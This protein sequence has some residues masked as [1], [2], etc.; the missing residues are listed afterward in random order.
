[1]GKKSGPK[2]PPPPDPWETAQAQSQYNK[3][4]AV[5]Q[6]N[7][8]RID[9]ITPQG[10]I[11]YTQIGTN[12]D[13]TPQYQQTMTYSPE[14]QALYNQQNQI[15]QQL[16]QTATQQIDRVNDTM[17]TPF[18]YDG[19]TPQVTSI[20]GAGNVQ[21]FNGQMPGV[22]RGFQAGD[23]QS[24]FDSGGAIQSTFGV[25]GPLTTDAQGG[26][27]Q[28]RIGPNDLTAAGQRVADSV[29][30]QAQSRLD[31]QFQQQQ[32]DLRARLANSGIAEGSEAYNRELGNFNRS[33]TDAYADAN[34]RA[35][36][37]GGA[38]QSRLF[39][40]DQAQGQF[41]N[42]AQ[43]QAY[44]QSM[45]N[46]QLN[47]AAQGQIFGQNQSAAQFGNQAQ[48]Q[49]FAQ[50]QSQGQFYNAAQD[51]DY[52]QQ[53]GQAELF[54]NAGQTWLSQQLAALGF[55]NQAQSQYMNENLANANLQNAG[56][57]QEIQEATYLRNLPLNDIAALLGTGGGV[58]SPEFNPVSQVGVAAP[59]YMGAAY[60]SN[61][62]LQNQYQQAQAN[63]SAGLGSIFG[64]AGTLGAAAI[65]DARFKHNVQR[66]GTLA[67]GLA[68]YVFS[69]LGSKARHFGVMAQEAVGIVPDAVHA[70]PDGTL[71]VDYGKV[72]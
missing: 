15:A 34:F 67:N 2:A 7:L 10:T 27:I 47:N 45:G 6:A 58:M 54:N 20:Q 55:N 40:I 68:T 9:Q 25:G 64:L 31:P 16:G 41:A 33:K 37:A 61:Q 50:N 26:D 5:A 53:L 65:S 12:A 13:G 28:R 66:I 52:T 72:W 51:Q 63:R 57:Q 60:N 35:I 70:L 42:Q 3:E 24:S 22:Q 56:R 62:I 18:N 46:A 69:Y 21:Q 1:M 23:V 59:D 14:Q 4:A 39:G 43:Q 17:N 8:N 49:Q 11:K 48:A 30:G 71:Y 38:E 44:G 19:M 29:Y 36:Q 32:N